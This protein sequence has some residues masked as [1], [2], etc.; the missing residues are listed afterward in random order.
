MK[1]RSDS[2]NIILNSGKARLHLIRTKRIAQSADK[3][4]SPLTRLRQKRTPKA[5]SPKLTAE[6]GFSLLVENFSFSGKSPRRGRGD[7]D[8]GKTNFLRR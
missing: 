4:Q 5:V 2:M 3:T 8:R 1:L 7:E 6:S